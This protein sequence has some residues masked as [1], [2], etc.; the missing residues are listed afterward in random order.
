MEG[1][2]SVFG[3]RSTGE[4]IRSQNGKGEG[5][6]A[7]PAAAQAEARS[8]SVGRGHPLGTVKSPDDTGLSAA[9]NRGPL[10]RPGALPYKGRTFEHSTLGG[11]AR[12][13][14][15]RP[16]SEGEQLCTKGELRTPRLPRPT[17]SPFVLVLL[18]GSIPDTTRLA[19]EEI[20]LQNLRGL[21]GATSV[22]AG[23]CMSRSRS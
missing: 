8:R 6:R 1:P 18:G 10:L 23:A 19:H 2:L 7:R 5:I 13:G 4:A 3:D 11:S 9:L 14:C 21:C 17:H 15:R 20:C 12:D 22:R 16:R